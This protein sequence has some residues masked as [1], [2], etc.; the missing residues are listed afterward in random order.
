MKSFARHT[1][2]S[3][4]CGRVNYILNEKKQE[5]IV[6][7]GEYVDFKEYA[8]YEKSNQRTAIKNNEGREV[9]ISIPN[10]WYGLP[11]NELY[12]KCQHLA[13][14]A[15]GK[16]TDMTWACHWNKNRTNLH[17][18]AVFSERTK[19]I[20]QEIKR[21]DR[22]IYL[23]NEG[24]VARRKADRAVDE[25][26]GEVLPPI[27]RKGDIKEGG[28]SVK[29]K[30]YKTKDWFEGTKDKLQT[31]ME[32]MGVKF[33]EKG[34][35][36]E[37][38][39]GKGRYSYITKEKNEVIREVNHRLN[40]IKSIYSQQHY[41]KA[42]N[43]VKTEM[44]KNNIIVP[45]ISQTNG[46]GK[47]DFVKFNN[48]SVAH[49]FIKKTKTRFNSIIDKI[50]EMLH[51]HQEQHENTKQENIK[52]KNDTVQKKATEPQFNAKDHA[53]KML[54]TLSEYMVARYNY[55][56]ALQY[57]IHEL[58]QGVS[59]EFRNKLAK[60]DEYKARYDD[61]TSQINAKSDDLSKTGTFAFGDKRAL[62]NEIKSLKNDRERYIEKMAEVSRPTY[63]GDDFNYMRVNQFTQKTGYDETIR[64]FEDKA[65]VEIKKEK[66]R[67]MLPQF[68]IS[69]QK[70][71]E[72]LAL[73]QEIPERYKETFQQVM[74]EYSSQFMQNEKI[75]DTPRAYRVIEKTKK[76]VLDKM[77]QSQKQQKEKERQ[78]SHSRSFGRDR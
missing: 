77:P 40:D 12:E 76:Y 23:T 58:Q 8:D 34:V 53:S 49:D 1:K 59:H 16:K 13:E 7:H 33:E 52:A 71:E 41:E 17:I 65:K 75:K 47:M 20:D 38:H 15:C 32:H 57:N 3:N 21:Y 46:K 2:L 10:E 19:V 14:I 72:F 68:D 28:F 64:F 54:K 56:Y 22:D 27:H 45:N 69:K 62:K 5:E 67:D 6:C 30:T 31:E 73:A 66:A 60:L 44:K 9:I 70:Q 39:E 35:L 4:I 11:R 29:D 61:L 25:K 43:L 26:T 55:E 48:Y 36:H 37:W 51:K 18:H 42:N 63:S 74:K 24:K 78:K 50:K